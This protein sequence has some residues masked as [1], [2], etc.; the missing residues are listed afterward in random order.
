MARARR[1]PLIVA[2]V[3]IGSYS[4]HLV[5]ARVHGR[6]L[7]S[8]H[9][10]SAFLNLGRSIDAEGD[11]GS[12]TPRLVAT[13]TRYVAEA[14][15]LGASTVVVA[16]TDPLRRAPDA[17]AVRAE[18]ARAAGVEV[19]VLS[20]EEEALIALLGVQAGRPIIQ[21]TVVVDVGG[22]STEVLV[23]DPRHE[24]VVA[25]LSLGAARLSGLLVA[26]D[27]PLPSELG[28]LADHAVA[29]FL[30]APGAAPRAMIAVGG[31]AR[32]LLRLGPPLS[33]RALSARRIRAALQ[34]LAAAPAVEVAERYGIRPSRALV[35][36][37]G[38]S[39]LLAALGHYHLDHLRVAK[40]GLREGLMLAR[41]HAGPSWREH[42]GDLARGW[43]P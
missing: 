20:H 37:A 8:L 30:D 5:V 2:A 31:T 42:I 28:A 25:G 21:E 35:L 34:L 14:R 12:A 1:R 23:A 18:I 4:V 26:N 27:P 41:V 7:D 10:E 39:I 32:S 3:D 6:E 16:G 17:A 11:I 13:L 36:P 40:G 19:V 29:A 9:D 22:G 15:D 43:D 38:A 33:N 24:P